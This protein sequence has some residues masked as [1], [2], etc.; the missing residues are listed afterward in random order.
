MG[1]DS[2]EKKNNNHPTLEVRNS[3]TAAAGRAAAD[4]GLWRFSLRCCL[5]AYGSA[6]KI[7]L[8]LK[9][10]VELLISNTEHTQGTF[11]IA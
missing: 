5:S 7:S 1:K 4:K 9:T 3:I 8:E 6:I 10:D 2:F 11:F